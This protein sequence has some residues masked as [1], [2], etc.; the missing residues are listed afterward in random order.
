MQASQDKRQAWKN[1]IVIISWMGT[2]SS[3]D[4]MLKR[5]TLKSSPVV[6]KFIRL[7]LRSV[8][9]MQW[10]WMR[11]STVIPTSICCLCTGWWFRIWV[12]QLMRSH[13]NARRLLWINCVVNLRTHNGLLIRLFESWQEKVWPS[14]HLFGIKTNLLQFQVLPATCKSTKMCPIVC[15]KKKFKAN[16]KFRRIQ[17]SL[18]FHMMRQV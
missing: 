4:W 7:F 16:S 1:V 8:P 11:T 14:H 12:E 9:K 18:R 15:W 5:M 17:C 3:G 6:Q 10:K 2:K 13:S